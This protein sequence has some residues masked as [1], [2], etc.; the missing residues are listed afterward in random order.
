M[1]REMAFLMAFSASLMVGLTR[2]ANGLEFDNF[3]VN[4]LRRFVDR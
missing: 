2:I 3:L 4:S 1:W